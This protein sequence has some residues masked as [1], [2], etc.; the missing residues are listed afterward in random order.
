MVLA[1]MA[2][3]SL[4]LT[5]C[6]IREETR[7][8][9]IEAIWADSPHGDAESGAF[10]HWN[11]ADPPEVPANCAKCHST[12]GYQDSLGLDGATPGQVDHP[13]PI[14]TTVECAVC[15]N[16]ATEGETQ[17]GHAVRH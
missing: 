14:G 12:P 2:L 8:K 13:V 5:G 10:T 3:F 16:D 9:K 15:H 6:S 1:T 11:D 7:R 17:F 4:I